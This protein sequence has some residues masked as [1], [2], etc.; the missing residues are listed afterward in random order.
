[1]KSLSLQYF[2]MTLHICLDIPIQVEDMGSQKYNGNG[3][4]DFNPT[5]YFYLDQQRVDREQHFIQKQKTIC[6][7]A[8]QYVIAILATSFLIL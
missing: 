3:K 6:I 2:A 1:M 7:S 4:L 8:M 5:L